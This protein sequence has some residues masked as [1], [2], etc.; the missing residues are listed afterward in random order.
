[1][2]FSKSLRKYTIKNTYERSITN[3]RKKIMNKIEEL[4][5]ENILEAI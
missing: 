3:W 2:V 1:M 5:K 4:S